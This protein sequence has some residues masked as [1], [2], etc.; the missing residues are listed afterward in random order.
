MSQGG[1]QPDGP[2][3]DEQS[4]GWGYFSL[5]QGHELV[6]GKGGKFH[7]GILRPLRSVLVHSSRWSVQDLV[8]KTILSKLALLPPT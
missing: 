7:G 1:N 8:Q 5:S 3:Q 4:K 6:Q 2:E